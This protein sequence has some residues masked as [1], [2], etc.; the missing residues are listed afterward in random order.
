MYEPKVFTVEKDSEPQQT[1]AGWSTIFI[2]GAARGFIRSFQQIH[3]FKLSKTG[4]SVVAE[5][6]DYDKLL[7]EIDEYFIKLDE[8]KHWLYLQDTFKVFKGNICVGKMIEDTKFVDMK[9]LTK[10]QVYYFDH[11]E[12]VAIA[13]IEFEA[14]SLT[15]FFKKLDKLFCTATYN[16]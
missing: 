13:G 5:S 8:E 11:C 10:K 16:P 2:G 3:E 1:S 9:T 15:D 6:K 14:D 7:K 12:N 4:N